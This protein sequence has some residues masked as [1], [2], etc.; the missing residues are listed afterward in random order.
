M[1]VVDQTDMHLYIIS[2]MCIYIFFFNV[3]Q[4]R[5]CT[6]GRGGGGAHSLDL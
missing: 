5:T 2:F 3:T 6:V 1:H 4:G